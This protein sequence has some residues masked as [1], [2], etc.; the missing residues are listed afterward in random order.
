MKKNRLFTGV[1][2]IL[3]IALIPQIL[4]QTGC[5]NII[6]PLGG[7]KDS[8]PPVVINIK[9]SDSAKN[10]TD[11]RIVFSFDEYVEIQ[12]VQKNLIVSPTPKIVP[13]VDRKLNTI[14]VKLKDTLEPH[15]T[16]TLNFGNSIK[17]LNE[18]NVLKNFTYLFSTGTYFDSLQLSGKIF[19]AKTGGVDT[20]LTVLLHRNTDDSAIV[21]EKPR[22]IAR[23]DVNGNFIFRNLPS[24]T[25]A[26]YAMKDEGSSFRFSGRD[27]LFAFA[28]KPVIIGQDTSAITLYAF[29]DNEGASSATPVKKRPQTSKEKRLIITNNLQNDVQDLLKDFIMNFDTPLKSFDTTK[30][31][32]ATDSSFTPVTG[33]SFIKDSTE[34]T[35]TLKTTWKEGTTYHLILDKEF[36]TDT[37]GK[38]LLKS[39]TISFKTKSLTDYGSVRIKF[40]K[41]DMSKNPV[42]LFFLGDQV[43]DSS[44][45]T[46]P[47]FYKKVITPG[48]YQLRILYDDNKNG[49]WDPGQFF[50]GRKQP[51]LIKTIAQKITVKPNW[52]ND[53]ERDI[54]ALPSKNP[55]RQ[56]QRPEGPKRVNSGS[57]KP[58]NRPT[59]Q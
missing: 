50:G 23:V 57:G 30:I 5:A 24:G 3:L 45:L 38:K 25:F 6:P 12:D 28:D 35:V 51:E 14:V 22:Y 19:L 36:A 17:D 11:N 31:G 4:V 27:Q 26:L 13:A 53:F 49:I 39:D 43:T 7:P 2:V 40:P 47:E 9:P 48:E 52:D 41:L 1:S 56:G 34:K 16:Y 42:L 20:T 15:T 37:L 46:T 33:Y 44:V 29:P 10:F 32:F 21:K 58:A 54:D 8:L 59:N 55:S 18:G